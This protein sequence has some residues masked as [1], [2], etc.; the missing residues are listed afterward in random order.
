MELL[1]QQKVQ[2]DA[3]E[4]PYHYVV[5]FKDSF[6]FVYL[7]D[8]G[9][10][11]ASTIE[12]LLKKIASTGN[13]K[14]II[15]IGCGDGRFTRELYEC[16]PRSLVIGVDYSE[17]SIRL[18]QGLNSDLGINFRSANIINDNLNEQF[19]SA[20]L[21]EVYEHIEPELADSFLQGVNRLLVKDGV[22]HLTVPHENIPVSA[23]HFRHFTI[24]SLTAEL[25]KYFEIVEV[26]PFEKKSFLRKWLLRCFV[27]K[28][29][30]LN[31]R[32]A[33]NF[34]YKFYKKN[35]FFVENEFECPGFK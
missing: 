23:H 2:E 17:R 33:K 1:G 22:L 5:K 20:A 9:I 3:Y 14:S 18:A 26:I 16:F 19:E 28:F 24:S 30:I 29:F 8:W 35:L 32:A 25:E 13:I 4:F 34:L 27:N 6:S 21:M 10:N 7:F 11:Y 31:L 12:F 15:D